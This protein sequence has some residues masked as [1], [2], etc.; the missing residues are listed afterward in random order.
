[1]GRMIFDKRPILKKTTTTRS[2]KMAY[3]NYLAKNK[4]TQ[5]EV[6]VPV[7]V[8][9]Q[10]LVSLSM[11]KRVRGDVHRVNRLLEFGESYDEFLRSHAAAEIAVGVKHA[12]TDGLL[13]DHMNKIPRHPITKR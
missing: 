10:L 5:K 8:V 11:D 13:A 7:A 3:Q 4:H 6:N 9:E 2:L 12:S 1:M